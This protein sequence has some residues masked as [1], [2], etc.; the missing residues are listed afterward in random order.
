MRQI[1]L[2]GLVLGALLLLIQYAQYRLVLI[3]HAESLY[4]ALIATIGCG[5]GIWAG[6]NLTRHFQQ[7]GEAKQSARPEPQGPVAGNTA[8]A[9]SSI[10][11][12]ELEVLTLMA[13]GLSNQE[14]AECLFLS[15]NT[16]KTHIS[17]IFSKLDVQRRTQAVQRA[18][19]LGVLGE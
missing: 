17:N 8:A 4:V 13:Q 3:Q 18:K 14:I 2:Y 6:I 16:V 1:I 7:K 19:E 11:A 10:T 5:A 12:R 9:Q 15:L